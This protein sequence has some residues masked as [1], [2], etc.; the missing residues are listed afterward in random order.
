MS[1]PTWTFCFI[2]SERCLLYHQ[3][4]WNAFCSL[5]ALF[6]FHSK[7]CELWLQVMD[8]SARNFLK[9]KSSLR[10]LVWLCPPGNGR[11]WWIWSLI[12]FI[13]NDGG[14]F[15]RGRKGLKSAFSGSL[16]SA[17]FYLF[18]KRQC[19]FGDDKWHSSLCREAQMLT[20]SWLSSEKYKWFYLLNRVSSLSNQSQKK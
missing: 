3:Y 9:E 13:N 12:R 18:E 20:E 1:I 11:N 8:D 14:L 4:T 2:T 16:K 5:K 10:H 17:W 19:L 7:I 15:W 6:F